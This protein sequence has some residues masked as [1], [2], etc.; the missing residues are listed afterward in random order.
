LLTLLLFDWRIAIFAIEAGGGIDVVEATPAAGGNIMR[1]RSLL[2]FVAAM[3]TTAALAVAALVASPT[4]AGAQTNPFQRGPNPT[5]ALLEAANGPFAVQQQTA[6][7]GSGFNG[8]TIFYPSDTS[9][10]TFGAI[11]VSPGFFT[12]G[13]AMNS[14][15]RRYASHGFVVIAIN[16]YSVVDFPASRSGQ[17]AAALYWLI[18]SSPVANR[19][20]GDRIGVSGHSMGGGGSL[21]AARQY[22]DIIDAAVPLQAWDAGA[23]FST[24]RVPTMLIGAQNDTVAPVASHSEPFYDQIPASAEKAYLELAG[25]GHGVG[26]STNTTQMKYAVAWFKRYIDDDTRYDQFLCP[27]PSGSTIAEYRH[28]CPPGS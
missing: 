26:L 22:G 15:A 18:N 5:H 11:G 13:S 12:P 20:D 21:E 17:L 25:Q 2:R 14:I 19:I 8:G 24:M 27:A 3:L 1:S 10:G 7:A 9:Q 28:T 4:T 6:A 16:T 23:N